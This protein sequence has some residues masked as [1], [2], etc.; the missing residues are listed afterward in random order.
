MLELQI[1]KWFLALL[2]TCFIGGSAIIFSAV[3]VQYSG[4]VNV[5]EAPSTPLPSAAI[6]KAVVPTP[7]STPVTIPTE[8]SL[9]VPYTLQ[10]PFNTW[11]ALHEDS[12]EETSLIMVRHF[13]NGSGIDSPASADQEITDLVHWEEQHN[14]GPSITLE[15]LNQIAKDYYGL[16]NGQVVTISSIDAVKAEIAAGHPVILGMS[17]KTLGNPYFTAGGPNYHM[18]VAKGYTATD[19]ITNEP[20][21]W[22]GDGYKYDTQTFY[23]SIHNWDSQNIL[24]GAKAYLVFK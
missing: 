1:M 7:A 14:Y 17:G 24:N 19:I 18:L 23:N 16:T 10:A 3:R 8:K 13:L 6:V 9:T 15:Q 11:D 4:S 12:C 22:H 21:T 2:A 20:G 5:I